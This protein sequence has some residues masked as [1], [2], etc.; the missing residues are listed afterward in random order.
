MIFPLVEYLRPRQGE[1]PFDLGGERWQFVTVRRAG[2]LDIGVYQFS[3]DL[4][5]D[6]LAW[7]E[8]HNL[9]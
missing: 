7:R 6:Y 5:I 2:V 1:E 3:T 4:C 8:A 9:P